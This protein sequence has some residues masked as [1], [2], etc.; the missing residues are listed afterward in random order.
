MSDM[1][2]FQF[3]PNDW[4]SGTRGL[5]AEETGVYI[6]IIATLYDRAAPI[7]N[8][9]DRL[10]RMCGAS[11]RTFVAALAKLVEDEKL[12]ITE[13]G[14]WNTRVEEELKKR[15]EKVEKKTK[16]AEARWGVKTELN[17]HRDDADALQMQCETDAMSEVR[18]QMS[19]IRESESAHTKDDPKHWGEVQGFLNDRTDALTDWEVD[20]L[21]SIKWAERLTRPQADSLKS[22]RDKI[23]ANSRGGQEVF[24]VKNGTPPFDAWIAHKKAQGLKTA[25][26]EKQPE[27][28]VPTL[29]P[30]EEKAA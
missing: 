12:V 5:S 26:L 25:F 13:Q 28:T 1:P 20:F 18:G 21:H 7:P 23:T 14:I 16:A 6:T 10:S 29:M 3:Y 19:E 17:Q 15:N 11:K 4:L 30:P 2:W 8:D 9:I 27:M 24:V 22:I